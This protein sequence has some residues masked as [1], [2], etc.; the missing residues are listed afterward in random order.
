MRYYS[1]LAPPDAF[2]ELQRNDP[3][4]LDSANIESSMADGGT[5]VVGVW[6]DID[7]EAGFRYRDADLP[8]AVP[9]EPVILSYEPAVT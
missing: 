4:P 5:L 8:W 7:D 1:S 3:A 6:K 2:S 9:D